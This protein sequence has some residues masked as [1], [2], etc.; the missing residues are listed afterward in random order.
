MVLV[1]CFTF[2]VS[3]LDFFLLLLLNIISIFRAKIKKKIVLCVVE[4]FSLYLPVK[5]IK[6]IIY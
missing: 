2:D 4:C 1:F 6:Y 5:Y 3:N